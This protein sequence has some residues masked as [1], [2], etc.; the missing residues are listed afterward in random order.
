G[1][2]EAQEERLVE[3]DLFGATKRQS[4]R[5][6]EPPTGLPPRAAYHD[7]TGSAGGNAFASGGP[8]GGWGGAGGYSQTPRVAQPSPF[9][10]GRTPTNAFFSAAGGHNGTAP[11]SSYAAPTPTN[12][13]ATGPRPQQEQEQQGVSPG[14]ASS[15]EVALVP[16]EASGNG[17]GVAMDDDDDDDMPTRSLADDPD[18][19]SDSGFSATEGIRYR[20]GGTGAGARGPGRVSAG[21]GAVVG[22]GA[23]SNAEPDTERATWVVVWG[24][25]PGKANEVLTRFLQFGDV[26]EQRGHQGSNWLYLKYTTRLQAEK[27]LAAGHGSRLTDTV[28]LGVQRVP[29]D[30][31]CPCQSPA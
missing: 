5:S 21:G 30:E 4:L 19:V 8:G 9:A 17:R 10:R 24:V 3:G 14:M 29:D 6:T 25:P 7:G 22:D 26:E 2:H 20:R 11:G 13:P 31:V 15:S 27:S 12:A 1:R 28:M 18:V 23:F 16:V